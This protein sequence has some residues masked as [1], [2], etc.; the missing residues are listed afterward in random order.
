MTYRCQ[1]VALCLKLRKCCVF[2]YVLCFFYPIVGLNRCFKCAKFRLFTLFHFRDIK[3]NF[4]KFSFST[5]SVLI[6][7]KSLF[8]SLTAFDHNRSNR[9]LAPSSRCNN[10]EF[11]YAFIHIYFPEYF[12]TD[13]LQFS[14]PS[15]PLG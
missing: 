11:G 7:K 1:I 14:L 8:Y 3:K 15:S 9:K 4:L 2:V 10:R 12:S 6:F 5:L 13:A